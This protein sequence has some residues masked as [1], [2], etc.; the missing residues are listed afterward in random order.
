MLYEI[1]RAIGDLLL[2]SNFEIQKLKLR[3]VSFVVTRRPQGNTH[4]HSFPV[5]GVVTFG[6]RAAN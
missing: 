1:I 6:E 2:F 4:E 3:K 5:G